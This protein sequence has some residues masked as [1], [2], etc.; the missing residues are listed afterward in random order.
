LIG[1]SSFNGPQGSLED[2]KMV[3]EKIG[4]TLALV[5]SK[6]AGTQHVSGVIPWTNTTTSSSGVFS[7]GS[8]EW[9]TTTVTTTNFIPW[10]YDVR[11]YDQTALYFM[12]FTT[13]LKLGLSYSDLNSDL[14][15]KFERNQGV[16]VWIVY[17]DSP[18]FDANVLVG[19]LI[20]EVN[21]QEVRDMGQFG[22]MIADLPPTGECDVKVIRH[23]DELDL[24]L[25]Y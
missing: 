24:K 15:A 7:A 21:G 11:R 10:G 3:C 14:R 4:A 20:V 6:Y 2:V 5:Y 19:D 9:T 1:I 18:A 17:K 12:K 13:K 23:G 8:G 25:N 22:R 16:V